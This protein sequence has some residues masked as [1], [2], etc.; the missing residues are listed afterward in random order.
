MSSPAPFNEFASQLLWQ[1]CLEGTLTLVKLNELVDQKADINYQ[2]PQHGLD[3]CVYNIFQ[4]PQFYQALDPTHKEH[5]QTLQLFNRLI[6]LKADFNSP[7]NNFYSCAHAAA[8]GLDPECIDLLLPHLDFLQKNRFGEDAIFWAITH[9]WLDNAI[10]ILE[11]IPL[12]TLRLDNIQQYQ[13]LYQR[14]FSDQNSGSVSRQANKKKLKELLD[15][16]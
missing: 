9:K 14:T 16:L 13:R 10:L 1:D 15:N 4:H 7:N 12:E 11:K 3:S 5:E 6:E 2:H 8:C